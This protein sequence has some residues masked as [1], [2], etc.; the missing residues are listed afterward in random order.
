MDKRILI[1]GNNNGLPGVKVDVQNYKVFFKS[2]KGGN[3]YDHEII[4]RLNPT[5]D[6]L[7]TQLASLKD[8]NL[9]YLIIVFSGHGGQER[10]TILE[11]NG[12]G[13]CINEGRLMNL[14]NRQLNIFDCCR[15]Y[16]ASLLEGVR[17][18][19]ELKAF[20]YVNNREKYERR[21]MQAIPQMVQ[22]YACSIGEKANDTSEVGA[23][24]KNLINSA[25][26]TSEFTSVG[27]AHEQAANV[28][29]SQF[30]N[31][32]PEAVLPRCLLSQQLVLGCS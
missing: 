18:R 2:A 25:I 17:N 5:Y 8:M 14:A 9:D 3:W 23:Y 28:T 24:S 7:I 13:E 32:N 4:E 10:E 30:W 20:S 16:S 15:S 1:I 21:I 11:L 12:G 27:V 29:S 19:L 6:D 31:Q 26:G 22:L